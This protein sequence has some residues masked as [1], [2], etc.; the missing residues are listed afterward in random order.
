MKSAL[1]ALMAA[2]GLTADP[3]HIVTQK[4]FF[5]IEIDR[6]KAGRIIIGLFGDAVPKTVANFAELCDGNVGMG[7]KTGKKLWY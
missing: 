3:L 1:F 5:D 4:V 7:K 6:K 2:V